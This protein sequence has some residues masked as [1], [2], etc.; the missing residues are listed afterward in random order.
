MDVL[1]ICCPLCGPVAGIAALP[2]KAP[3][4]SVLK[5]CKANGK[6]LFHRHLFIYYCF[7]SNLS[8]FL[9][10]NWN[11]KPIH[12]E[13]GLN[14][15]SCY[16][17]YKIWDTMCWEWG[18]RGWVVKHCSHYWLAIRS[19]VLNALHKRQQWSKPNSTL[20]DKLQF[21]GTIYS[22]YWKKS[23]Q[24]IIFTFQNSCNLSGRLIWWRALG[25]MT[26][27]EV[28]IWHRNCLLQNRAIK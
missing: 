28:G 11:F 3:L 17:I 24:W 15:R 6:C 7:L 4:K 10:D 9:K 5:F 8:D 12:M 2:P 20:G 14:S 13:T 26:K 22:V 27:A 23:I 1:C 16:L 21:T 18:G 25:A 19:P